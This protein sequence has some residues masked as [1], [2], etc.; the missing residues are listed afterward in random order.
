MNDPF[1]WLFSRVR[2]ICVAVRPCLD[3]AL[4]SQLVP[5]CFPR[6]GVDVLLHQL[7]EVGREPVHGHLP[8]LLQP[9]LLHAHPGGHHCRFLARQ[10]QV[11]HSL[12]TR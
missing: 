1:L 2:F 5:V 6:S 3:G 12:V 7:P 11:S 10:I 4:V 8:R 9:L